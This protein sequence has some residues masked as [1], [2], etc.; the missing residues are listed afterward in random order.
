MKSMLSKISL[1]LQQQ[2]AHSE[3]DEL[4][5]FKIMLMINHA[6]NKVMFQVAYSCLDEMEDTSIMQYFTKTFTG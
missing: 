4:Q 3:Q 6:K 2:K 5:N 1:R